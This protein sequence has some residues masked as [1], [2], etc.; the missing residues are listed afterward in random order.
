[1]DKSKQNI[2]WVTPSEILDLHPKVASLYSPQRIG[3]LAMAGAIN[4]KKR[5]RITFISEQSFL[6]FWK[7]RYQFAI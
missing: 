2:N 1:M 6:E 4:F 3:Y 7:W 5:G